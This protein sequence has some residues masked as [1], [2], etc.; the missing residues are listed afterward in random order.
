MEHN[1]RRVQCAVYG[2]DDYD[3]PVLVDSDYPNRLSYKLIEEATAVVKKRLDG[4]IND[5]QS[6]EQLAA[7]IS[8]YEDP[9]S[10]DKLTHV[11]TKVDE[12]RVRLNDNISNLVNNQ[13]D[14]EVFVPSYHRKLKPILIN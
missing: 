4:L 9:S 8:K 11:N 5:K 6:S 14:L 3:Q 7:L 12:V 1:N 10:L 2:Y 13:M